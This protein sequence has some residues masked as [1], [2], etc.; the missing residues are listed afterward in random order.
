MVLRIT[1]SLGKEP[2]S[3]LEKGIIYFPGVEDMAILSNIA[4]PST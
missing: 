1:G 3:L 2:V 4:L